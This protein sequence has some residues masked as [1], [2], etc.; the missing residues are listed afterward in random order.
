MNENSHLGY[1]TWKRNV[2]LQKAQNQ[3]TD[4]WCTL[5]KSIAP[6]GANLETFQTIDLLEAH[7][8]ESNSD[9]IA[10]SPAWGADETLVQQHQALKGDLGWDSPG[11]RASTVA[12]KPRQERRAGKRK[13]R[14]WIFENLEELDE[15]LEIR[16]SP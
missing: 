9:G 11:F 16:N 15:P 2:E 1:P 13:E 14:G 10:G 7:M 12:E 5:C 4:F 3:A 8:N 6:D